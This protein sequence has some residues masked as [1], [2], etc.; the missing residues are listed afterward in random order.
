MNGQKNG[1]ICDGG[2][3]RGAS[4]RIE[5]GVGRHGEEENIGRRDWGTLN[6]KRKMVEM[7][8]APDG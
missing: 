4:K 8:I 2:R 5:K 7:S 6:L 3:V 1:G